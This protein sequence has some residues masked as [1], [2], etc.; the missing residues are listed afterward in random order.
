LSF[1]VKTRDAAVAALGEGIHEYPSYCPTTLQSPEYVGVATAAIRT[2]HDPFVR[3]RVPEI[4]EQAA[5][6]RAVQTAASAGLQ[7]ESREL[8]LV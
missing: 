4:S 3:L 8:S 7:R 2:G 6:A 1:A 5:A